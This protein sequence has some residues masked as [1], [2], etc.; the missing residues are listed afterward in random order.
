MSAKR[1][2][3]WHIYTQL[4][5]MILL[6]M[7]VKWKGDYRFY[8]RDHYRSFYKRRELLYQINTIGRTVKVD[9]WQEL[10][11]GQITPMFHPKCTSGLTY[12]YLSVG[13]HAIRSCSVVVVCYVCDSFALTVRKLT[14]RSTLTRRLRWTRWPTSQSARGMGPVRPIPRSSPWWARPTRSAGPS[15]W[16]CCSVSTRMSSG[17][18]ATVCESLTTFSLSLPPLGE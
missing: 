14:A 4:F 3:Q 17:T 16:G 1:F 18:K 12:P 8:K 10:Q 9:Y 5:E 11:L 6:S 13:Y 7:I 2:Q 15:A